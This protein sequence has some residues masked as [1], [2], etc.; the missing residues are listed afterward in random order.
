MKKIIITLITLLCFATEGIY[1]QQIATGYHSLVVKTDGTLWTWGRNNYGQLGNGTTDDSHIPSKMMDGVSQVAVSS[2]HSL[3]VNTDGT[4]WAWGRNNSGQLGNGTSGSDTNIL[5]PVKI[6]DGVAHVAAGSYHSL[7]V[8]TDGSLWAWGYNYYGQLGNGTSGSG[9]NVSTPVKIMDGVAQVA[10]GSSHSL[11]VKTDGSLWAWGYNYDGQLGNGTSGSGTNVSTPVKIMDGVSKIY[12]GNSHSLA[13]KTDGSLWA[14]G[15]NGSFRLGDGTN[16]NRP[17]PVKIMD[18]VKMASGGAVNTFILKTDGSLWACGAIDYVGKLQTG[19]SWAIATPIEIMNGVS[20]VASQGYNTICVTTDGE[21]MAW[22]DNAYGQLGTPYTNQLS[23]VKVP[24]TGN[25]ASIAAGGNSSMAVS[26]SGILYGWGS[27]GNGE[28]GQG[29]RSPKMSPC[30]ITTNVSQAAMGRGTNAAAVKAD[31]SLWEWGTN[32]RNITKMRVSPYR[33]M[34]GIKQVA[35]GYR[36]IFAIKTDNSL[37]AWGNND[38][39]ELG[40]GDTDDRN[41]PVKVMDGVSQV[42]AGYSHSLALKSD[43]SLWAWGYNYDGRIGDGTFGSGNGKTSPVKVMENVKQVAAGDFHSLALKTDGTLWAW[44]YNGN[45]QLGIGSYDYN[46]HSTPVQIMSG[47][48]KIAAG[49]YF[50]LAIKTDGSLWAWGRN[51]DGQ[52]GDGTDTE[53]DSP[54]KVMAGVTDM[55]AGSNHTLAIK[56]DGSLWAWGNNYHGE[57]GIGTKGYSEDPVSIMNIVVY[58]DPVEYDT[59]SVTYV[60]NPSSHTATIVLVKPQYDDVVV[61]GTVAYNGANYTVTALAEQALASEEGFNYSVALPSTIT[62]VANGAF[63]NAETSAII[64][65]S[66]TALPANAFSNV[67]M[68]IWKNMLLYV[69]KEGIAPSGFANTIVN[70]VAQNIELK[71]GY[72]FHC[73][74]QFTAQKISYTHTFKMETV[75]GKK[76]GWETIALPFDVMSITHATKGQL[77]PFASYSPSSS[78]KPF[79][80]YEWTSSGFAKASTMQA[81]KPYLISMP[82]NSAYSSE[83]NVAGSVTFSAT[84][85]IVK[86]TKNEDIRSY[87]YSNKYFWAQY[88]FDSYENYANINSVNQL[89]SETGGYDPGSIFIKDI[90]YAFPFEGVIEDISQNSSRSNVIEIEF[91]DDEITGIESILIVPNENLPSKGIYTISGMRINA[92]EGLSEEEILKRLPSGVYIVNGKK[93]VVK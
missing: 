91:A 14:W 73:P 49:D 70:G 59:D 66:N 36:N 61:S 43:G 25:V 13:I 35:A 8:K 55:A 11:A 69:N 2:Y 15:S 19:T 47:V 82:N 68:E 27:N 32:C 22:G 3:A 50:S 56:T 5:T 9:T 87:G 67:N 21:V 54:V 23:P 76:Q 42:A 77:I 38:D 52:I 16:T 63:D 18:G 26:T 84:N 28:L 1:A 29:D 37:W 10:A 90:R 31:N 83:Y 40:V 74:Q 93:R 30:Q 20:E 7:A 41:E 72:V 12:A 75:I 46:A 51:W 58:S 62:T 78:N 92:E 39:G 71:E 64:W 17:T 48:S 80:L 4:L 81:N 86:T 24:V 85:A 60:L 57:I 33:T 6:M 53:Q 79:W 34:T 65:N 44:G 88:F 45:G 89:H